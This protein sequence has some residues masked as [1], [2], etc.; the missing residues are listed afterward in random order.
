MSAPKKILVLAIGILLSSLAT[1]ANPSAGADGDMQSLI[2]QGTNR[3]SVAAAVEA[4]GGQI[5]NELGVINA[6]GVRLPESQREALDTQPAVEKVYVNQHLGITT[7]DGLRQASW[8]SVQTHAIHSQ[9]IMG[10]SV[11]VAV[12][13]SGQKASVVVV[14]ATGAP[15]GPSYIDA[16]SV[17]DW[18]IA[19]KDQYGIRVLKLPFNASPPSADASNPFYQ[20]VLAASEAQIEVLATIDSTIGI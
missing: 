16:I 15:D 7:K 12:L 13:D 4:V 6:F 3:A 9:Q 17:I 18:A 19:N 14:D 8:Q 20:A 1:S 5:T 10:T 11:Y 2:V